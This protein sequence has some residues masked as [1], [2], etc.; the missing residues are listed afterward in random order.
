[1]RDRETG[2]MHEV[3]LIRSDRDLD[4]FCRTYGINRDRIRTIY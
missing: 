4:E 1:M 3:S 2:K